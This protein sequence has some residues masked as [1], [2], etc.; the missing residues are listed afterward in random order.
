MK[1]A[2]GGDPEVRASSARM[3]LS[4]W[5]WYEVQSLCDQGAVFMQWACEVLG[6][7]K[8][9]IRYAAL[10]DWKDAAVDASIIG[11]TP[12]VTKYNSTHK[13]S[14]LWPAAPCPVIGSGP[15]EPHVLC[16]GH[17]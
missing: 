1:I 15:C 6:F 4:T 14:G 8:F 17:A 13:L 16:S 10:V 5:V 7:K 2:K 3:D 9:G 11:T 12:L